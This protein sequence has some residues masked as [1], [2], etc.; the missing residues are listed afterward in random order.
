MRA[1][2]RRCGAIGATELRFPTFEDFRELFAVRRAKS[3]SLGA[4]QREPAADVGVGSA[5]LHGPERIG[6]EELFSLG[7]PAE[8]AAARLEPLLDALPRRVRHPAAVDL[9]RASKCDIA[10][11]VEFEQK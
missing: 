4:Q 10:F 1:M 11:D 8:P 9:A 3:R 6:D 2:C 5:R 7:V